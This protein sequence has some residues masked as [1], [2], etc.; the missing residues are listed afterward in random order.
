MS[1]EHAED[2]TGGPAEDMNGEHAEN[3]TG[4]P[5]KDLNGAHAKN[6]NGGHLNGGEL[7]TVK[8]DM[9]GLCLCPSRAPRTTFR[10]CG[11]C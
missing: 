11:A 7:N 10:L 6:L 8:T 4:G 3:L 2:L 1:G 5:A 9:I